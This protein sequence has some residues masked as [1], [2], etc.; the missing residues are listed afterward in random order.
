MSRLLSL[1]LTNRIDDCIQELYDEHRTVSLGFRSLVRAAFRR[2]YCQQQYPY[3]YKVIT[4]QEHESDVRLNRPNVPKT[5]VF[6]THRFWFRPPPTGERA[7][8]PRLL[9]AELLSGGARMTLE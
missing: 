1:T 4:F 3:V 8:R 6:A 9:P 7:V 2:N 5:P